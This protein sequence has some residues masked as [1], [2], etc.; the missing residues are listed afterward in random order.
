MQK[1]IQRTTLARNQAA[2]K[3]RILKEK[4]QRLD[5]VKFFRERDEFQRH[6]ID[7]HKAAVKARHEDWYKGPLAPQRD[8]GLTAGKYGALDPQDT[9]LPR[10]PKHL[11]RQFINIAPGDRVVLLTG[12]DQGKIC[13]VNSVDVES[14]SLTV[15]DRNQADY[16]VP[17]YAKDENTGD[18]IVNPVPIPIDDVRLVCTLED[19]GHQY[20]VVAKHV[21][22]G[23][24]FLSRSNTSTPR[25]TRYI[26]GENIRIPW[27]EEN[28]VDKLTDEDGDTSRKEVEYETWT[29]SLSL[30]PFKASIMDE[31]RNKYSKYRTRHD[32]AWV[33]AK[34]LEDLRE[35][36]LKSRK[37]LTPAGE[38]KAK[39]A[40]QKAAIRQSRKDENGNYIMDQATSDFIAQFITNYTTL[41][42]VTPAKASIMAF[43]AINNSSRS[44]STIPIVNQQPPVA[45]NYAVIDNAFAADSSLRK[46]V[47]DAI[48]ASP[49]H[50]ALFHDIAQYT[51]RLLQQSQPLQQRQLAK[52][53]SD[54]P[55]IKKRKLEGNN[56]I[57]GPAPSATSVH[58]LKVDSPL[59]FYVQDISFAVP[60]RKKLT[61]EM[62]A[63]GGY[64][65]ARNQ[66]SKEIEFG[67]PVKDI[68]HV[69]CLPV[70][71]KAQR[72]TNFCIIP[73]YGDGVTPVPDG[74]SIPD[75]MVFTFADGP[76]KAAF[77]GA[78]QRVESDENG[79]ALLRGWLNNAIGHTKV[80]RPDDREFVSATPEAHRKGEK[81]YHVKAHRGSKDGYLFFLSTGILFGFKKPLVFFSFENIESVSYTSVLQRTFNLNITTRVDEEQEPQE[82]EF[83][84]IDQADYAG[85]DAYIKNHQLQDAS[86]A[87][88]RRAKKYNVNGG[89]AA[90]ADGEQNGEGAT[91]TEG[92]E[93]ET[94]LQKAQRELEDQE[95]EEEEDY[96]PGS[97][98]DSDGSGSSSEEEDEDEDGG[99]DDD[100][101]DEEDEDG[102]IDLVKQELGSE[103]EHV[104]ED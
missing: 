57:G 6:Q 83:S 76:A 14:E 51:S 84:M 54:E 92:E 2:R 18:V 41:V 20:E 31:L 27:P 3:A 1:V 61:L 47:Y 25:H 80:I 102:D 62:T 72:Q 56:G 42:L 88:A 16:R 45:V 50:G 91:A 37:L 7:T 77:T 82:V 68:Q 44:S 99:G 23:G 71:E 67:I 74:A 34:K 78:G 4:Q 75:Q 21:H 11:R 101:E 49:Q 98:G 73:R 97:E 53:I 15:N 96:D 95:D 70:P 89:K 12:P 93:E 9:I 90:G 58:D 60:Q 100:E 8:S 85:I 28:K 22:G 24:P 66:T 35:E 38:Y 19:N 33:E 87:E 52:A 63:A 104:D 40:E 94:E 13:E 46:R 86:L 36:F 30:M 69:L 65:R 10:I 26:S 64:L 48:T 103:A 79:E 59:Q 17:G 39:L 81:A 29:P 55:A 5:V 43:A 32:P